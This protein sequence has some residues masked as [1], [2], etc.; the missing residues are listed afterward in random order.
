VNAS[1]A[2]LQL[3]ATDPVSDILRVLLGRDGYVTIQ[4]QAYF[5]ESGSHAGSPVLCIA[6]Y[7]LRKNKAIKFGHEWRKILRW[8]GLPYFHMVDCAHG[9]GPFKNLTKQERINVATKMI[10]IIKERANQRVAV[11]VNST[12][13]DAVIVEYP[14]VANVYKSA[15]TFCAHTIL[16]GVFRWIELNPRV[17]EMA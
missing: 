12:E 7:I 16:A 4:V 1:L 13:Y 2:K 6:G 17:G 15:Y 5:D 8:K 10:E 11:T 3:A 9:N 14:W